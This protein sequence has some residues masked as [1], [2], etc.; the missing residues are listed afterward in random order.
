[1]NQL[2][3]PSLK[4][5]LIIFVYVLFT[6]WWVLL[7]FF[8]PEE[9]YFHDAFSDTYGVLA[10]LSGFVG[11]S[12]AGKWGGIKSY[13]G[14]SILFL[15]LGLLLQFLGQVVYSIY[16][17]LLHIEVPYPS[18]GDVFF[19]GSIPL[20]VF[21]AWYLAK[22][23]GCG[24]T[25]QK[26]SNK[27]VSILLPLV[28]LLMSYYIFLRGI[29]VD[30]NHP[31]KVFLDFGYPLGQSLYLAMAF[32]TYLLSREVLGGLMKKRLLLI[33]FAFSVQYIADFVFLYK[34]SRGIWTPGGV[35]E[36]IYLNAYF[37]MAMGL[38]SLSTVFDALQAK[39]LK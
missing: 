1:M 32:L 9:S 26:F 21:G 39:T 22:A 16:F 36:L 38:V 30:L 33:L 10:L 19:F 7:Q 25:F 12:I 11:I 2:L 6:I 14:R 37:I 13:I 4:L 3:K 5:Y 29:V 8:I 24:L 18:Y 15:A 20:Y 27:V 35:S 17:Y 23:A 28:L 34:Q 31:V